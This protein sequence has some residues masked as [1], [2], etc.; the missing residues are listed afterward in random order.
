MHELV[1]RTGT[2]VAPNRRFPRRWLL[3]HNASN[4]PFE[5]PKYE[6]RN[7]KQIQTSNYQ[8]NAES[9]LFW[10]LKFRISNLFRISQF[11]FRICCLE[12]L[13]FQLHVECQATNLV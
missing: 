10:S 3:V 7:T 1:L 6:F 4:L 13:L 5:N 11:D 2:C 8:T 9:S 12:S